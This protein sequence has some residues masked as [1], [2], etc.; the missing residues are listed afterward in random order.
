MSFW[1]TFL[2]SACFG[3]GWA[4]AEWYKPW[5][6]RHKHVKR[7]RVLRDVVVACLIAPPLAVIMAIVATNFSGSV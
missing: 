7:I 2:V 1:H 5:E 6:R 3:A 4:F